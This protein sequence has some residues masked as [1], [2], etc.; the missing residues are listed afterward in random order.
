VYD[1]PLTPDEVIAVDWGSYGT[2]ADPVLSRAKQWL[3][4]QP[5]CAGRVP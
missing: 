3:G 4:E 5:S 2:P 1:G